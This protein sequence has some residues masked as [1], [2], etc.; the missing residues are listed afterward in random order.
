[1]APALRELLLSS[2]RKTFGGSQGGFH[3][4]LADV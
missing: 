2:V 1:M 3:K 4:A